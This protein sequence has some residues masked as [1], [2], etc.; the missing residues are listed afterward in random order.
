MPRNLGD[1]AGQGSKLIS[2]VAEI[3]MS[4]DGVPTIDLRFTG[5]YALGDSVSLAARAAFVA[6]MRSSQ[7]GLS[8]RLDLVFPLEGSWS[9]VALRVEQHGRRVS[10]AVLGN[11]DGAASADIRARLERIFCLDVD[12]AGFVTM[13]ARDGVVD[14]LRLKRPGLRP[15][16]LP[17]PYEAAARAIIGQQ[18]PV[19]QAAAIH[20]RIAAE[21][22]V[23]MQLD[24]EV[25]YGFPSPSRLAE[26]GPVRGLSERKVAHLRSLA[27]ATGEGRLDTERL[28]E[29]TF[30]DAMS[31]LQRLPGIGPFSA[32]LILLRGVGDPDAFPLKE[33]R[34]HRAMAAAYG[35]GDDADLATLE[36]IADGWRPYRSWA[37]LLL[38]DADWVASGA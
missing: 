7:D 30:D 27:W 35:L 12:G 21:H 31:H 33:L 13:A 15:V 5:D 22:G 38:R 23:R 32:E 34:L 18:L 20:A 1:G 10:A 19:R 16:L 29:M 36:R 37:G 24:G 2:N 9:T 14:A 8:E 11:P 3:P 4:S 26:L 25:A 17:S 28:R 6:A